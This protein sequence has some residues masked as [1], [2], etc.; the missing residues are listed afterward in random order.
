MR[1]EKNV[2]S[3][4]KV[5][6]N[7][8]LIKR[9]YAYIIAFEARFKA[10]LQDCDVSNTNSLCTKGADFIKNNRQHLIERYRHQATKISEVIYFNFNFSFSS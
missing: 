2:F 4:K 6:V 3:L 7:T 9:F 10:G 5:N 1:V 8:I